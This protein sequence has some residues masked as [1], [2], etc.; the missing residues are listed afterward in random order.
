MPHAHGRAAAGP[1]R[2]S[3]ERVPH[4]P[5][6]RRVPLRGAASVLLVLLTAVSARSSPAETSG[7]DVVLCIDRSSGMEQTDP[8]GSRLEG[9]RLFV[10]LLRPGDRLALVAYDTAVEVLHPLE[11]P[12]G[13]RTPLLRA[14]DAAGSSA[15]TSELGP[16]LR[17]AGE[18]LQG[19][20]ARGKAVLLL[21]NGKE[22]AAEGPERERIAVDRS[23]EEIVAGLE[24]GQIRICTVGHA[25]SP[26]AA[27]LSELSLR[28]GGR[29]FFVQGDPEQCAAFTKLFEQLAAP[30]SIPIRE[31]GFFV[32]LSARELRV[33]LSKRN[34]ET[35]VV[36]VSPD[37]RVHTFK[38]HSG[39]LSWRASRAFETVTAAQPMVGTWRIRHGVE[40]DSRAFL[41]TD[42]K[43]MLAAPSSTLFLGEEI[44]IE[45]W[46]QQ[47]GDQS[48]KVPVAPGD[49]RVC[50][51]LES[52]P[53]VTGPLVLRDDGDGG[54]ARPADGVFTALLRA[55]LPGAYEVR[56]RARGLTFERQKQLRLHARD[57]ALPP[58]RLEDAA[59]PKGRG[60]ERRTGAAPGRAVAAVG[61]DRNAVANADPNALANAGPNS[62]AE[63]GADAEGDP[64]GQAAIDWPRVLF[65]FAGVNAAL[66]AGCVGVEAVLRRMARRRRYDAA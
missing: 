46:M 3:I 24:G 2:A 30:D 7:L 47:G 8:H 41:L 38:R 61:T 64:G 44:R 66:A 48:Q 62:L 26:D 25:G 42:L 51:E 35:A 50:A 53:G 31:D 58:G 57:E 27:I 65:R 40:P 32:D 56:V 37:K 28:T 45:A 20:T 29:S 23:L 60:P 15:G 9:A 5:P 36:L 22:E 19:S 49:L 10:S 39:D 52:P 34:A 18:L 12:A 54:D 59:G 33:V 17:L 11:E 16:V 55:D 43:L 21:S 14:L 1:D 13:D 6:A 63:A 4:R